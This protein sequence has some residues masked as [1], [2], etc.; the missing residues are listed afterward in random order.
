MK[1]D[2]SIEYTAPVLEVIT[3]FVEQGFTA[4]FGNEGE[5]GDNFDINDNGGF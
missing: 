5:A 3:T 2:Y 4:S 1:R